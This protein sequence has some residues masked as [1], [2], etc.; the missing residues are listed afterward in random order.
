MRDSWRRG[1]RRLPRP[2]LGSSSATRAP[3]R[4]RR[5][6]TPAARPLVSAAPTAGG[7]GPAPGRQR[8]PPARPSPPR[9][10]SVRPESWRSG[11]PAPA[12][13]PLL[14]A[15]RRSPRAARG[16]SPSPPP[17]SREGG[18]GGAGLSPGIPLAL[19]TFAGSC[20]RRGAGAGGGF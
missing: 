1:S 7:A 8:Q 20:V 13:S 5:I 17:P 10:E 9:P 3:R 2:G 6:W 12:A 14:C 16:T 19:V 11:G 4:R 15:H 18:A